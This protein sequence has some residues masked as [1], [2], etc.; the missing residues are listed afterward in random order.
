MSEV[1]IITAAE[2]YTQ[3]GRVVHP[4]SSPKDPG[5]SPGKKPL[6]KGWQKLTKTPEN[7]EDYIKKGC[8]IGGVC[9]KVSNI[10]VVDFDHELFREDL[11]KD[12]E[13]DTLMASRTPGRGHIYFEYNEKIPSQK[14]HLLGIEILSDGSNVVLP[15][16]L[17]ASGDV[18]K[19][20]DPEK[21]II[22]MPAKFVENM[23]ALFAREKQLNSLINKCRPCFKRYWKDDTKIRHGSTARLFLGAFCSELFNKGADLD[24]IKMFAK[25]I[26]REDYN[27]NKTETEFKGWTEKKYKP[28]TCEKIKEQCPG[29]AACETCKDKKRSGTNNNGATYSQASA[30]IGYIASDDCELFHDDRQDPYARIKLNGKSQITPVQ[31]RQFRRWITRLFYDDTG[32][33]PG[34][35]AISSALNVI[36]AKACH[37]GKEYKLHNR[38]AGYN[39]SFWYDMGGGVAVK[40]DEKGWE[41]VK[42]PPILFKWHT[43]QKAQPLSDIVPYQDC[44]KCNK[45][46][47]KTQQVKKI[48][49]FVNLSDEKEQLL[50]IV[51]LISCFIPNIPHPIPVLYGD[52]GSA[53][54]TVFKVLKEIID[55]S[56]L[57]ILTFPKDNQELV[58]KLDHHH[59]APFDNVT[60]LSDW[61]SD[62]LCRACSGEGFSKRAHYTNDEDVL[63][64]YQ[65]CIGLNGVNIVASKA[66]LLDRC[67]LFPVREDTEG[68]AQARRG[69]LEGVR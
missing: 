51:Y 45:G 13:L 36:E 57:R 37:K 25:I 48:L 39:G 34:G 61:Q 42:N 10:T 1:E 18:Y 64:D 5:N 16:S 27:E 24:M 47:C 33:A 22:K 56:V 44:F 2:K 60:T 59:F 49:D 69:T 20:N 35:D 52:K 65:R 21:K 6:I 62:A 40:I 11:L 32:T 66:D 14:H 15:P 54:S 41:I 17:H 50:F 28:W 55:P 3:R 67:I 38:I 53:K 29:F 19:W 68:P 63:F 46:V 12:F 58:Q 8:N 26:Y 4:L 43:H 31:A 7:I 9:G 30:L 23:K